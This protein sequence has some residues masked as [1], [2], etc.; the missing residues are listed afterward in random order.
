VTALGLVLPWTE[1]GDTKGG[2]MHADKIIFRLLQVRCK[3][4]ALTENIT[5]NAKK[6]AAVDRRISLLSTEYKLQTPI[7]R[8]TQHIG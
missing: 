3:N 8:L 5:K 6:F 2:K 1:P 4:F 7:S